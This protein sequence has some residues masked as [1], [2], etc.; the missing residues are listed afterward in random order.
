MVDELL[1]QAAAGRRADRLTFLVAALVTG[2]VALA[3]TD[4]IAQKVATAKQ[5]LEAIED[6]ANE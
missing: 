5:V 1:K 2:N 4:Q 6:A 3:T